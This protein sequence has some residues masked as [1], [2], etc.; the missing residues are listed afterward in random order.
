MSIPVLFRA[1]CHAEICHAV[2][3]SHAVDVIDGELWIPVVEEGG[4]RET[5]NETICA[6]SVIS[7]ESDNAVSVSVTLEG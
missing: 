5:M 3:V 4:C 1:G 6:G 2:I 7:R